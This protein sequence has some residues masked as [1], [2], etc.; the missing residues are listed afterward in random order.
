ME[1]ITDPSLVL[2]LPL[3]QLDGNSIISRDAYGHIFTVTG[4]AWKL[5]GR[6]FDGLDD[7][8]QCSDAPSLDITV[9]LTLEAW[10][11][12][13][14]NATTDLG[15]LIFKYET[16]S[17]KAYLIQY[18]RGY[19]Q[20][21]IFKDNSTGT[22]LADDTILLNDNVFHHIAA[23]YQGIADGNS[24][25]KLFVDAREVKSSGTAVYPVQAIN[26][27][28]TIGTHKDGYSHFR[29]VIGEVR[30]YNRALNPHEIQV[31]SLSTM[32]RYR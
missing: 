8:L 24:I 27:P 23:T 26:K 6:D 13:D 4:A 25:M 22:F 10:I 29:G 21:G 15:G 31:N 20:F 1:C 17:D 28:L 14:M 2:N 9:A 19:V 7:F 16:N 32:W 5:Q 3:H 30:I 12:T 18:N 11:K